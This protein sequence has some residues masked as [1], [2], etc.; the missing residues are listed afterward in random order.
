M[1]SKI[2]IKRAKRKKKLAQ[3]IKCHGT[4][5]KCN[6]KLHP[7]KIKYVPPVFIV[8]EKKPKTLLGKIKAWINRNFR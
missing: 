4:K 1:E 8:P 5:E 7:K 2:A 6:E 3:R